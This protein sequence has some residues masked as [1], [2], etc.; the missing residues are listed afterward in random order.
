MMNEPEVGGMRQEDYSK[1]WVMHIGNV[2]TCEHFKGIVISPI[3]PISK[4]FEYC[5]IEKFGDLLQ[6]ETKQFGF[7]RG[8]GCSHAIYTVCKVV[9]R[10]LKG[11]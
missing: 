8:L 7:K 6:S 1:D 3:R 2:Y 10:F 5:I 9:G 4:I 11:C